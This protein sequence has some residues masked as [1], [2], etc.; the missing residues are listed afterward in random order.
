MNYENIV[1]IQQHRSQAIRL[2]RMS[3]LWRLCL[4]LPWWGGHHGI[5]RKARKSGCKQP[6]SRY[7]CISVLNSYKTFADYEAIKELSKSRHKKNSGIPFIH[8]QAD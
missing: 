6:F 3:R 2:R 1:T 5:C 8:D 7:F 4:G